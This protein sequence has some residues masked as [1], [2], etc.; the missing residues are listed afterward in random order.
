[1]MDEKHEVNTTSS[2]ADGVQDSASLK[3]KDSENTMA[4]IP[5]SDEQYVVTL[6]T[7]CVV[8]VRLPHMIVV[9]A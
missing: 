1:M 4:Y 6:K 3:Q 2:R 9:V 7:W 8:F 5:P